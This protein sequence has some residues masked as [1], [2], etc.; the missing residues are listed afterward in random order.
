[1]KTYK[2]SE[3]VTKAP[4]YDGDN[5]PSMANTMMTNETAKS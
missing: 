1:M 2:K 5:M 3:L 4:R